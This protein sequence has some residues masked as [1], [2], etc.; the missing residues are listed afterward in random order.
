MKDQTLGGIFLLGGIGV[1][2]SYL[3][4]YYSNVLTR[5]MK[6]FRK[7]NFLLKFWYFSAFITV[8]SVIYV[9]VYYTFFERLKESS[10]N[11]FLISLIIFLVFAMLWSLSV[12]L[13]DKYKFNVYTQSP[14]LFIVSLSTIGMLIASITNKLEIL[15]L[16]ALI[17]IVFHHTIY[18]FVIWPMIHKSG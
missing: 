4:L 6:I 1:L 11:L 8:V 14:I 18:D 13:I 2:I 12:F 15:P 16:I 10:R 3:F 5:L 9:I 17:V 7:N